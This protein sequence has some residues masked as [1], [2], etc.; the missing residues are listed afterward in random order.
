MVQLT[1]ANHPLTI[2]EGLTVKVQVGA[3]VAACGVTI[4]EA[5]SSSVVTPFH[6]VE[7]GSGLSDVMTSIVFR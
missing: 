7:S 1:L 3:C 5:R 2:L 4:A 6:G